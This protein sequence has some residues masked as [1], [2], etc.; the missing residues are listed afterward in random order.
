MKKLSDENVSFREGKV[1]VLEI[2][3]KGASLIE[4]LSDLKIPDAE[5]DSTFSSTNFSLVQKELNELREKMDS[6]T[7]MIQKLH[8]LS[9]PQTHPDQISHSPKK[10]HNLQLELKQQK[11]LLTKALETENQCLKT[12][13]QELRELIYNL[14]LTEYIQ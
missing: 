3:E 8:Q 11:S 2:L 10:P 4:I 12:T 7:Q 5:V 9:L 14:N 1:L 13:I 6:L